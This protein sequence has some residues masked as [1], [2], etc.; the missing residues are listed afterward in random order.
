MAKL[1]YSK[2]K[3]MPKKEFALVEK[4]KGKRGEKLTRKRFP[5]NDK[6]HAR[7]ALARLPQA[8][9]LSPEEYKM[10]EEKAKRKLYG[11]ANQYKIDDI[12]K[13]RA[14]K[15]DRRDARMDDRMEMARRR[16]KKMM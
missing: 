7:N 14:L 16:M 3:K 8:K 15:R 6:A 1:T 2:R 13:A 12:K 4:M 11:T 10:I 9:G 5:I